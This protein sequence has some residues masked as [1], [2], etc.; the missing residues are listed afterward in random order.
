MCVHTGKFA[1]NSCLQTSSGGSALVNCT[2]DGSAINVVNFQ[3]A[4]CTGASTTK[5]EPT[6]VRSRR[7]TA[8]LTA[9]FCPHSA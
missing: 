1:Q 9:S 2:K 3:S 6:M 5:S 7:L 4:D 8:C